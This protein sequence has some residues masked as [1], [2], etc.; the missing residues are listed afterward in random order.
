MSKD[1]PKTAI[2][3]GQGALPAVLVGTLQAAGT[4]YIVAEMEGFPATVPGTNPVRF[5][6]E[7]LVPLLEHL[8]REGVTRVC[9][10]GAVRRPKIEPEFFDPRTATL[11]PRLLAALQA[12]DDGALRVIIALFEEWGFTVVGA[13]EIAPGLLPPEGVVTRTAPSARHQT[14]AALGEGVVELMGRED[15]GQASIIAGGRIVAKEG[16]Q[17]TDAMMR[18][19]LPPPP[20]RSPAQDDGILFKAPKPGQDRRIDLP[21]IGPD[22]AMLAAEC[23]LAGIVIEAGGVIVLDRDKVREILDGFGMFLWVRPHGFRR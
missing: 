14:D 8:A 18:A 6:I 21:T 4:P 3:A 20:A 11:V 19:L 9:F 17:G 10:A 13:H 12:G 7:R 1:T 22:T 16:P 2:I 15:S 5:R 23:G